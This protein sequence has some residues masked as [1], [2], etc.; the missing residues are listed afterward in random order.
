LAWQSRELIL[1]VVIDIETIESEGSVRQ[2]SFAL[3]GVFFVCSYAISQVSPN[4]PASAQT[5]PEQKQQQTRGTAST[6][7]SSGT[8]TAASLSEDFLIGPEDV[9]E[10]KLFHEPEMTQRVVVR[11][12]GKI[13]VTLL[14]DVQASGLSTD[15]LS[16][17]LE[18]KLDRFYEQP[19]VS[20]VASE[21]HSQEV[22]LM[23]AVARPG[24]YSLGRPLTLIELLARAG[25]FTET[26]KTDQIIIIRQK[27]RG[28]T[29]RLPFNYKQFL[30]GKS[31]NAN[32]LMK[33]GD[34]VIIP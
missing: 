27:G 20:V 26:A 1:A 2:I 14:G 32:I 4:K 13:G 31:P 10:I 34:V 9:L 19:V 7:Q 16:D 15:K 28:E 30:E 24:A 23:G 21:I 3:C 25:G 5:K 22:H 17:I 6:A 8:T 11:S 12:D 29:E 33:S 18:S